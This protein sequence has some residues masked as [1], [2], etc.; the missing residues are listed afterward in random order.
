MATVT[1]KDSAAYQRFLMPGE[2]V[3]RLGAT[4]ATIA[5]AEEAP[6]ADSLPV[7]SVSRAGLKVTFHGSAMADMRP[8]QTA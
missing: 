2:L 7:A 3:S 6:V 5:S 4:S 8:A 1:S